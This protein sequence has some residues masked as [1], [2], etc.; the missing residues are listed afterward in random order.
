MLYCTTF[1]PLPT[2]PAFYSPCFPAQTFPNSES[3]AAFFFCLIEASVCGSVSNGLTFCPIAIPAVMLPAT[4]GTVS[5]KSN[6]FSYKLSW[7]WRNFTAL[8]SNQDT[9]LPFVDLY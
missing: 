4:A 5:P 2:G 1:V 3:Y 6:A 7:S 9:W 8:K